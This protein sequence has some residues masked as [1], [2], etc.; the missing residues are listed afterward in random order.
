M[1]KYLEWREPCSAILHGNSG[2]PLPVLIFL[3]RSGYLKKVKKDTR[4]TS[5]SLALPTT[6]RYDWRPRDLIAAYGLG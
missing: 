3:D 4:P 2:T 5:L 6:G 1:L